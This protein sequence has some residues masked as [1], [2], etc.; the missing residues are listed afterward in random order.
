MKVWQQCGGAAASKAAAH[1]KAF[2]LG[3][4]VG[5]LVALL[6]IQ[7]LANAPAKAV[8]GGPQV[9]TPAIQ[10]RDP[11]HVPGFRLSLAQTWPWLPFG[12][13]NQ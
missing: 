9:W 4:S 3:A 11:S 10:Q 13:E 1:D 8:E 5:V 12:G 6:P 7:L 2:H